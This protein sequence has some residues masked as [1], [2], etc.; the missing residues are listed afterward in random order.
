MQFR[1]DINGLRAIAVIAVVLFH[2]NQSWLPGG[3]VGVDVFFVISGFLMTGIIVKGLEQQIFSVLTFYTNRARRIIPPLA[4]LCFVLLIFTWF[5]FTPLDYK[6][7]G[8][9]VLSSLS[10]VSNIV[11]WKESGYFD[12]VSQEKW[13]LH[14]WSL[15]VE[16][17]FYMIYPLLLVCLRQFV[18]LQKMKNLVLLGTVLGFVF[19]VITTYIWPNPS[20]YLLPTR[21]WEMMAG[22]VAYLYPLSL[23]Q[24]AKKA[25]GRVGIM[26][27]IGS[28]VGLSKN[29]YWPG[30]LA[31]LPVLGAFLVIQ[32]QRV[33]SVIT[34]NPVSQK[35]GSWS[36]SIYLW[37]WP[38][39]VAAHYFSF[40]HVF[41]VL[42]LSVV[43]AFFSYHY[44]ERNKYT[45]RAIRVRKYIKCKPIYLFI[46]LLLF[47]GVIYDKTNLIYN[48]P[49][50]IYKGMIVNK[51]TDDNGE[52]T[53]SAH[54]IL[55][56]KH[57]FLSHKK[58]VL[59]I[60]DSQAGDL[61]NMLI[62]NDVDSYVD[63][64]S[65]MI[66][67]QCGSFYLSD[68]KLL[69]MIEN[70]PHKISDSDFNVCIKSFN[71]IKHDVVV[72]QADSIVLSMNWLDAHIPSILESIAS[73]K[74]INPDAELYLIGGKLFNK[75]VPA[76]LYDA[77]VEGG[78]VNDY[79]FAQI[80]DNQYINYAYQNKVFKN[81]SLKLNFNYVNMT[82]ILCKEQQCSVVNP[83]NEPY[84]Y[85]I[86]H[87][88]RN[89]A[90]YIGGLTEFK[91]ALPFIQ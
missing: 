5:F 36:Y 35:L 84:Y 9:H 63:L 72:K 12:T 89:G 68:K 10:F 39:I 42:L 81:N 64:I 69:N 37:H 19:C 48:L 56:R 87:L 3:F 7:L 22:G 83:A 25:V 90:K 51:D 67:S 57:N 75:S 17:Q 33:D 80:S 49:G 65:R 46:S 73:I 58:K 52:Y 14:T 71:R 8:K 88:T 70:S 78:S 13:L 38:L 66:P 53:W 59:I 2:F 62:A 4:F 31:L 82:N 74:H 44:I 32:S 60:G 43:C 77:Y 45:G 11:Y 24:R 41:L 55:A 85:D 91:E 6:T 20:F 15:S 86:G 26:L 61:T 28:Y 34:N 21:A 30:Y 18:S 23:S 47:S 16:W 1:A 27:I 29:S 54:E 40:D 50:D 76:M 79:A